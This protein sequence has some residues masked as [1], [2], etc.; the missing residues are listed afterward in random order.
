[1]IV[2]LSITPSDSLEHGTGSPVGEGPVHARSA[3]GKWAW[4][5]IRRLTVRVVE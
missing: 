1:L 3:L 2:L 4:K 5:N